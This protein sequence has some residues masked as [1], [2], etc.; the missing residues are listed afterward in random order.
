[1]NKNSAVRR[2]FA[3]LSV[4]FYKLLRSVAFYVVFGIFALMQIA[5]II[6]TKT[7]SNWM[8]D[9]FGEPVAT[10][11]NTLF[12]SSMSYGTIGLYL[13]IFFAVFLCSE[14]RT[15]TIRSKVTQGYSRTCVYFASLTFTYIVAAIAVAL[16]CVVNAAIGIPV[17]GWT[18]T[19][20]ALQNAMYSL[21]AL[22][23]LVALI[24]TLAYSSR[25]MG[26]TLGVGLPVIIV[27]PTILGIISLFAFTNKGVEW[28][29]RIFFI[30]LEEFVPLAL[31]MGEAFKNLALNV[32]LS[33][34]LWTASF[35]V[36]GYFSFTKQDIK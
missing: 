18:H 6:L 29:T 25:S 26:I 30:A 8:A 27:L 10:Q 33:Y 34:I 5:E 28:F 16:A 31:Q 20:S 24:H 9:L 32:C 1:M 23:P 15:N 21:F 35:I 17:L 3:L 19:Q 13:V 36:I 11:A 2:F 14:F 4:D 7:S 22:V 12:A